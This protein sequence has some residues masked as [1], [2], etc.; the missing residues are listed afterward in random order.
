MPL[1]LKFPAPA[2]SHNSHVTGVAG[3]RPTAKRRWRSI[4]K[5]KIHKSKASTYEYTKYQSHSA[6]LQ[7]AASEKKTVFG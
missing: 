6:Y 3:C 4:I 7:P 1:K 2:R 5:T